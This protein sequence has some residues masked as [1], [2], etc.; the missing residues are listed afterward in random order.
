MYLF[1]KR[2]GGEDQGFISPA[3]SD[4]RI[5]AD[6]NGV[7]GGFLKI[8]KWLQRIKEAVF[9]RWKMIERH[10]KKID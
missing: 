9:F 4:R 10:D 7:P 2:V 3:I 5:V 8:K 6:G 1:Y